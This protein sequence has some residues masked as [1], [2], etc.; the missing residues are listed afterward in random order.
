M[1]TWRR[2]LYA[3]AKGFTIKGQA[4]WCTVEIS[5]ITFQSKNCWS[6][7]L[8]VYIQSVSCH[9]WMLKIFCSTQWLQIQKS[10]WT[11]SKSPSALLLPLNGNLLRC[12]KHGLQISKL[13]G[14]I[15]IKTTKT[16]VP[17]ILFHLWTLGRISLFVVYKAGG[18]G[19]TDFQP[20]KL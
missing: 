5:N 7:C 20:W 12:S 1:V 11:R 2:S 19:G 16:A 10:L 18:R 14:F 17:N 8:R 3:K 4:I 6:L 15:I 9:Q 13:V